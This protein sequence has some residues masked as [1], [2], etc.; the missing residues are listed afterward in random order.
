[1]RCYVTAISLGD[2]DNDVSAEEDS[3]ESEEDEE[4]EE[5][6]GEGTGSEGESCMCSYSALHTLTHVYNTQLYKRSCLISG[7]SEDAEEESDGEDPGGT[8]GSDLDT[9][10]EIWHSWIGVLV[11]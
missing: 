6:G 8:Y 3:G 7:G 9:D 11:T 4:E 10:S 2:E 1:M 5:V